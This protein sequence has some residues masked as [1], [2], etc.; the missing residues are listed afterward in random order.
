[1]LIS[2]PYIHSIITIYVTAFVKALHQQFRT[3]I[4]TNSFRP[5]NIDFHTNFHADN[6]SGP[7]QSL[8][9]LHK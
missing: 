3:E 8:Y 5:K 7:F 2:N 6:Q 4:N 1:M 9:Y